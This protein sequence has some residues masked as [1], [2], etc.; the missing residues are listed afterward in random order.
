MFLSLCERVVAGAARCHLVKWVHREWFIVYFT[1]LTIPFSLPESSF[2]SYLARP[3]LELWS[4]AGRV[5]RSVVG[6]LVCWRA[7]GV[8]VVPGR[9]E[10]PECA[11]EL[12]EGEGQ[13]EGE[14]GF[15][16]DKRAWFSEQ[17]GV[18]GLRQSLFRL[19]V[20]GFPT[21]DDSLEGLQQHLPD[22]EILH[23]RPHQS[24]G[25]E[26]DSVDEGGR[27][28]GAVAEG[29]RRRSAE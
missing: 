24:A 1:V 12:E 2:R 11:E 8:Y 13:L 5:T 3:P 4:V 28:V 25:G 29:K 21:H 6:Y 10:A 27:V 15:L 16:I 18:L 23:R 17:D 14:L 20:L 22:A 9:R 7:G 26:R 19:R